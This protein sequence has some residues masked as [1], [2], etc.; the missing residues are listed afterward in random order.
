[1]QPVV[2]KM[3][4]LRCPE[5]AERL[6]IFEVSKKYKY[7]IESSENAVHFKMISSNVSIVVGQL[8]DI[9]RNPR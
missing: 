2:S 7:K 3:L 4:V 6:K 1:M 9:R 8:E 5:L